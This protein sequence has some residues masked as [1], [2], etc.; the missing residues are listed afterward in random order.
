MID[1]AGRPLLASESMS[2]AKGE[3]GV[4]TTTRTTHERR[5][6]KTKLSGA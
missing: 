4:G 5:E 6:R 3:D 1:L 2:T